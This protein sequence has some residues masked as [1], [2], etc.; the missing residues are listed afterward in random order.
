MSGCLWRGAGEA[1][2]HAAAGASTASVARRMAWPRPGPS[3]PAVLT[4]G[5]QR[6]LQPR[7]VAVQLLGVAPRQLRRQQQRQAQL[8]AGAGVSSQPAV[9][10]GA[11]LAL[12]PCTRQRRCIRS[13]GCRSGGSLACGRLRAHA[14]AYGSGAPTLHSMRCAAPPRPA[15]APTGPP[16][17]QGAGWRSLLGRGAGGGVG[18]EQGGDGRAVCGQRGLGHHGDAQE[19]GGPLPLAQLPRVGQ[20]GGAA[21][22]AAAV[23]PGGQGLAGGRVLA[24]RALPITALT[25]APPARPCAPPPASCRPASAPRG[26][27]SRRGRLPGAA[28]RWR[29]ARRRQGRPPPAAAPPC[30]R[31]GRQG[32]RG[33]AERGQGTSP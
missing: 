13:R 18:Q 14:A 11:A 29:R 31:R 9:S 20:L 10:A 7:G 22:G 1:P 28:R 33:G 12:Q 26:W 8:P 21:G 23:G 16:G 19:G 6:G 25:G 2:G 24:A 32:V 27:P 4:T 5:V 3:L 17:C 30:A 15:A